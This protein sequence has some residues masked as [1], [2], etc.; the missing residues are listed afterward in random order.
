MDPGSAERAEGHA[1]QLEGVRRLAARPLISIVVPVYNTP[2]A[3]LDACIESVLGQ[4]YPN[5]ELC[6]ADDGSRSEGTRAS[7]AYYARLDARI[8]VVTAKTNRGISHASNLALAQATGEYVAL[9]D[10]DDELTPDALYQVAELLNRK[11][12]TDVIYSDEDKLDARGHRCAPFHKPDWSPELLWNCMYTG[13]LSVYRTTLVRALGGFRS[14]FDFSQDYDL[15]LRA[16]EITDRIEH[17]PRILYHWRQAEGS[18]AA[19]GKD[20]ARTSN[21]AAMQAAMDRRGIDAEVVALPTA[22]R[23]KLR[24]RATPRVSLIIPTDSERNLTDSLRSI[25]EKT[26]YPDLEIVV[27]TNS[28]LAERVRRQHPDRAGLVFCKFDKPFNFS[29]KC[30]EGA[31]LASG[32]IVVFF[33]DDVRP[34]DAGWV[35]DLIE[36]LALP[37]VGAVAP[38]L[39]YENRTIQHAGLV[40]G[41][42]GLVGTAFH[43]QPADSN[44]YFNFAVS[45][46]DAS[47]ISGACLAMR[48]RDFLAIGGYDADNVPINHSDVDLCFRVRE[49]GL[50]CVYTPYTTLLHI[51]HLS[52]REFE[53]QEVD[54]AERAKKQK[55]KKARDKSDVFLLKRWAGFTGHD[56]YYT[57][58]MRELLYQD[59]LEPWILYGENSTQRYAPGRDALFVSHDLSGSGAPQVLYYVLEHFLKTGGFA[60]LLSPVDGPFRAR[61]QELGVPVII[62]STA[63]SQ[64]QRL[65]KLIA[66]FDLVVAN[67]V[68]CWPLVDVAEAAGVPTLWYVHESGHIDSPDGASCRE[69]LRRARHLFVGSERSLKVCRRYNPAARVL[70]YGVPDICESA[71]AVTKTSDKIVF[72]LLGSIERRKGQDLFARAIRALPASDLQR[73]EFH[74]VGRPLKP[75]LRDWLIDEL[76]GIPS[77]HVKDGVSHEEYKQLLLGSDVIVC[78]SRDDTLPLVTLD[79]LAAGKLLIC[80]DSTGTSAYLRDGESGLVVASEDVAMLSA[81]LSWAIRNPAALPEIGRRARET[82]LRHFSLPAFWQRW[83]AALREVLGDAAASHGSD[84]AAAPAPAEPPAPAPRKARAR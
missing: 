47:A 57:R 75:R 68:E 76:R 60:T 71:A 16:T 23:V 31:E 54:E 37:E 46:R 44:V 78:P 51:G 79:A 72:S 22:N 83:D 14:E 29:L 81:R 55:Q 15:A 11:P 2:R 67:T 21:I 19:G 6:L 52:L 1:A 36:Y 53:K 32:E 26:S 8:K 50:R 30:N 13:H 61:F 25:Y 42:R 73:A 39:L 82:F 45:V 70:D 9:L 35:D 7:L 17:I 27:V 65:A 74:I 12:D 38:K 59:S 66:G 41:V 56:P 69:T 43:I 49:H 58:P 64:P 34:L 40:T 48:K 20:Y 62:D 4:L 80:T 33:N 24:R 77:A 3:H 18:A 28:A 5:W 63:F 84:S 10:H